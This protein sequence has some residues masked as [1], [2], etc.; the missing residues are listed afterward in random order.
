MAPQVQRSARP[1][2]DSAYADHSSRH[3]LADTNRAFASAMR[4]MVRPCMTATTSEVIETTTAQAA[5]LMSS[6]RCPV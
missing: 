4:S 2:R 1:A 3:E 6:Q 5:T